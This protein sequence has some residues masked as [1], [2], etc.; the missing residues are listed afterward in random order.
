MRAFILCGGRSGPIVL[1]SGQDVAPLGRVGWGNGNGRGVAQER[2]SEDQRS[3]I[4]EL[5]KEEPRPQVLLHDGIFDPVVL[6]PEG[7]LLVLPVLIYDR[8]PFQMLV[9]II[10]RRC[11]VLD[12]YLT[13]PCGE[14]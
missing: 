2:G 12:R 1:E 13:F 7:R 14:T 3:G 11:G 6:G 4:E 8:R 5:R 9:D 10:A